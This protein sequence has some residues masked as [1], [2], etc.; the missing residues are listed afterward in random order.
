MA[1]G[2]YQ[3]AVVFFTT[4]A[5]WTLGN[6]VSWNGKTI[7]SLA[8]FGTTV[9][10]AA[11]FSANT[12]VGIN[13]RYWTFLTW[14]VVIGS[15][16]VM[17]LWIVIYSFFESH[18]FNNEVVIL[19][20]NIPFWTSV[21]I[22]IIIA[23]AP[24]FL[25]KF[26]STSY[27]PLDRDIVREMWVYGDL[28]DHLGIKHRK[29]RKKGDIEGA[30]M[31]HQPHA[32]SHSEVSVVCENGGSTAQ[33]YLDP[34][35]EAGRRTH[36]PPSRSDYVDKNQGSGLPQTTQS[37]PTFQHAD[38]V[39]L[40]ERIPSDGPSPTTLVGPSTMAGYTQTRGASPRQTSMPAV[41]YEMQ[42]RHQQEQTNDSYRTADDEWND[43][44][45]SRSRSPDNHYA[46]GQ[47]M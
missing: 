46:P 43:G 33:L 29:D 17:L 3:S 40:R 20:G 2:L 30:P 25:V 28:K 8:D 14:I 44:P 9:S 35:P 39:V 22:S 32:R 31:F 5:I 19:F 34:L 1:D 6:V 41:S 47:A 26:I 38:P 23:L 16:V 37:R 7:E 13:T 18:D 24:R 21:L 36:S 42:V 45:G 27:M 15:S 4:Y 10:V 12:Y 11:I